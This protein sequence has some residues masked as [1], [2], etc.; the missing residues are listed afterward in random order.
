MQQAIRD[1]H[2]ARE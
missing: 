2:D 1:T